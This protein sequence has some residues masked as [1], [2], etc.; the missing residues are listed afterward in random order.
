MST[1]A[2]VTAYTAAST[3]LSL[4]S[5]HA[6][7]GLVAG[8]A[9]RGTGIGGTRA[10]LDLDG[11]KV[12]L[13][14]IPLTDLERR[15]EHVRSTANLFGLPLFYQYGLGSAG[16]GAWRELAAHLMTTNWVL[17]GACDGFP[18]LYHW[19]VLPDTPSGDYLSE[20]AIDRFLGRW[21]GSPAV[22]QRL[23]ALGAASASV[24]VFL[25]HVPQTL[26]EW[27]TGRRDAE[28]YQWAARELARV[29]VFLRERGMVHFDG[30]M[31]NILT[32]G[33]R[34]LFA[35]F[36]LASSLDFELAPA[37]AAFVTEHLTYDEVF[38]MSQ[39]LRYAIEAVRGERTAEE[40]AVAWQAGDR[41]GTPAGLATLLDRHLGD[42]RILHH[43]HRNLLEHDLRTP[44]PAELRPRS[45]T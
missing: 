5:D 25:E 17:S 44:F 3:R 19:R 6:L 42:A 16:F 21:D 27:L 13:K 9:P 12:F 36:G 35:D 29:A 8:A 18:L 24:V 1:P 14:R 2:R 37:E 32:D 43:F 40:F 38:A 26:A 34:L 23:E 45:L 30:H 7:A 22:R 41:T 10:E 33:R 20:E 15:P 28:P 4:L 31:N 11:T 39:V